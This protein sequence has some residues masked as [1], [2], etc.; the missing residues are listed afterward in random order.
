MN[1]KKD[2]LPRSV[3]L[4][5]GERSVI[6]VLSILYGNRTFC[7]YF[8]IRP[9]IIVSSFIYLY[10]SIYIY[11]YIYIYTSFFLNFGTESDDRA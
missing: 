1:M 2:N 5:Y 8:R 6:S 10:I 9:Q 7:V 11:I 4:I 3:L